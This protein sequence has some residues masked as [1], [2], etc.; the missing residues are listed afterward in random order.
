[1][2]KRPCLL[3]HRYSKWSRRMRVDKTQIVTKDYYQVR[4]CTRCG[5]RHEKGVR[6]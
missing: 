1:M 4:V 5:A 6:D 2:N 3:V